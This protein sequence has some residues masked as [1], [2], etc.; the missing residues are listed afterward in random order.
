MRDKE[1][2]IVIITELTDKYIESVYR[3]SQ[4]STTWLFLSHAICWNEASINYSL[5]D[6]RIEL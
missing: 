2:L 6:Y 4:K 5:I 1:A 3:R